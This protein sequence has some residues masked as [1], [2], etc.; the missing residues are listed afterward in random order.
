MNNYEIPN[1]EVVHWPD[2][3]IRHE[4]GQ[5]AREIFEPSLDELLD[6]V[7]NKFA[8]I[9]MVAKRARQINNQAPTLIEI[10]GKKPVTIALQEI[11]AGKIIPVIGEEEPEIRPDLHRDLVF[12]VDDLD[13][14]ESLGP[15][16]EP[17]G[18]PAEEEDEEAAEPT[19]AEAGFIEELSDGE[20]LESDE[21][22]DEIKY[23]D[24]DGEI[25]ETS[26]SEGEEESEEEEHSWGSPGGPNAG[27]E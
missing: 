27:E 8:L 1:E 22:I 9:T 15:V 7:D 3:E 26:E 16:A 20:P 17:E 13:V 10:G 12:S 18:F 23:D 2:L 14:I 25:A 21:L 24:L 6:K 4:S 19:L 11:N 5:V